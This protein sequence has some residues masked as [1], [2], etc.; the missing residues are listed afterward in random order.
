MGS[1]LDLLCYPA[2][3]LTKHEDHIMLRTMLMLLYMPL[4]NLITLDYV[5][6]FEPEVKAWK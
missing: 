2:E 3:L 6:S 5:G 4:R 1:S